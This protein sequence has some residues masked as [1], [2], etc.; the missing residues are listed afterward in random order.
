MDRAGN[1]GSRLK[2]LSRYANIGMAWNEKLRLAALV[3]EGDDRPSS[4]TL[5]RRHISITN[6]DGSYFHQFTSGP[7]DDQVPAWGPGGGVLLFRRQDV[8]EFFSLA[9][10]VMKLDLR[11]EELEELAEWKSIDGATFLD[12]PH[13]R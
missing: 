8:H 6:L 2:N 13:Y 5:Q 9:M 12:W 10:R 3:M 7:C 1:Y 11:T 4:P